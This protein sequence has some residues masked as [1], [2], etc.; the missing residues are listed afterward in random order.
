MTKS[1]LKE[2][3]RESFLEV[4]SEVD[5]AAKKGDVKA[6]KSKADKPAKK[7]VKKSADDPNR[8]TVTPNVLNT[9]DKREKT[10]KLRGDSEDARVFSRMRRVLSKHRGQTLEA[11]DIDAMIAEMQCDDDEGLVSQSEGDLSAKQKKIAS[12]AGDKNKIDADDFAALRQKGSVE[13]QM[14]RKAIEKSKN[15]I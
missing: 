6:K 13:E 4:A 1:E 2:L 12:M 15:L 9:L 10:N 7:D 8:L 11:K 14:L 3:I 5:E